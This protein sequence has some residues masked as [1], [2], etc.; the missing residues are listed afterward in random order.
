MRFLRLA[1]GVALRMRGRRGVRGG[2]EET[3]DKVEEIG[4][5]HKLEGSPLN[6][7]RGKHITKT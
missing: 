3:E 6:V 1:L 2:R 5:H 7:H 4:Q